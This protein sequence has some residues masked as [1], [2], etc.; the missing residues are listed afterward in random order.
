MSKVSLAKLLLALLVGPFLVVH[1][2]L[3]AVA[4][5][6]ERPPGP[7]IPAVELLVDLAAFPS[8]WVVAAEPFSAHG[9]RSI[10][11]QEHADDWAQV[12]FAPRGRD[13]E[14]VGAVHDV[15][16]FADSLEAAI[17]FYTRFPEYPRYPPV[18]PQGIR[19][20]TYRSPVADRFALYCWWRR[21]NQD[22]I[23]VGQYGQFISEFGM[24]MVYNDKQ[25]A[26][27]LTQLLEAIDERMARYLNDKYQNG[28]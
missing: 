14:D 12:T 1:G 13:P 7:T 11:S 5:T 27:D 23:A 16:A 25:P 22:C 24:R 26:P 9:N 6:M 15:Y 4:W 2:F 18:M 17:N 8:G 3:C 28:Q 10:L 20:W 19:V 21:G